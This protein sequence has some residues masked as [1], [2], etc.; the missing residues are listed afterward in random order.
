MLLKHR[1]EVG[2]DFLHILHKPLIEYAKENGEEVFRL[3]AQL[4]KDTGTRFFAASAGWER[5]FST[6]DFLAASTYSAWSGKP[7]PLMPEP[8]KPKVTDI[9]MRLADAALANMKKG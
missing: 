6:A 4:L 1:G 5:P 9:E 7:H 2:F 3:A 8:Q